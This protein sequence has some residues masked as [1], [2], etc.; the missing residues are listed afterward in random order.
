MRLTTFGEVTLPELNGND[1][2]SQSARTSLIP[3]K[4]GAIDL[5]NSETV[6]N[7]KQISRSAV[8]N[9]DFDNTMD[10]L[11][12]EA[13]KGARILKSLMRDESTY[14][15]LLAKM[16]IFNKTA[17][18]DKYTCEQEFGMQWTSTYPYWLLSSHE[19]YYTNHGYD[20]SDGLTSDGNF[21]TVNIN[22]TSTTFTITNASGIRIPKVYFTIC[23]LTDIGV[24]IT[25]PKIR[26]IT[27]QMYVKVSRHIENVTHDDN[28]MDIDCLAKKVFGSYENN[29]TNNAEYNLY[30]Y[31]ET[32]SNSLD[33]MILEPGANSFEITSDAIAGASN[34][35]QLYV[36]WSSHF[37]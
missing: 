13:G 14:R 6:L 8:I 5:D 31:L 35:R 36:H 25:N 4:Y 30:P 2:L 19:P 1:D 11:A 12:N 17:K 24:Y 23:L 10:S 21:Q 18:A 29:N 34:L 9:T 22:S 20:T 26:N 27:N 32:Y 15:Q 33:W 16:N 37:I 28:R 7:Y 3:L